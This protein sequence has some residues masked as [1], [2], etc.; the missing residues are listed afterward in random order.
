MSFSFFFFLFLSLLIRFESDPLRHRGL[1]E[2]SCRRRKDAARCERQIGSNTTAPW[3]FCFKAVHIRF[4]HTHVHF[5]MS[6]CLLSC[7]R[8]KFPG[9]GVAALSS[10]TARPANHHPIWPLTSRLG[11]LDPLHPRG[12]CRCWRCRREG[13]E[14]SR[15]RRPQRVPVQRRD[16]RHPLEKS[17]QGRPQ[18]PRRLHFAV[19]RCLR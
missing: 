3:L 14:A 17:P 8:L 15:P 6:F 4:C 1:A 18:C 5:H 19:I 12:R 10:A 2:T 13:G 11:R 16:C 7:H 9:P